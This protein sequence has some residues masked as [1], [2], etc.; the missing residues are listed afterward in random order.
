MK[1]FH[2]IFTDDGIINNMI[3]NTRLRHL[4]HITQF[5]KECSNWTIGTVIFLR[6]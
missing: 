6:F 1:I 3:S 5:Y 2:L 4:N